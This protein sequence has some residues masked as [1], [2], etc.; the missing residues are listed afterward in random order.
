MTRVPKVLAC[1]A[2]GGHPEPTIA[3]LKRVADALIDS[4]ADQAVNVRQADEAGDKQWAR[5]SRGFLADDLT[6]ADFLYRAIEKRSGRRV[7][8]HKRTEL[9]P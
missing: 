2:A 3:A 6:V 4:A 9:K 7:K 1:Y 5:D 8:R